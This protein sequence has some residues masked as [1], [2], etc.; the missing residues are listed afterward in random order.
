M[1]EENIT[2][3]DS[4]DSLEILRTNGVISNREYFMRHERLKPRYIKFLETR[5]LD[6]NEDAAYRFLQFLLKE[7]TADFELREAQEY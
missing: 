7:E 2:T 3:L 5:K 1:K 4:L 6:N